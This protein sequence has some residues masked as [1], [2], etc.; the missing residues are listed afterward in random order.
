MRMHDYHGLSAYLSSDVPPMVVV[1]WK[2][3]GFRRER[4]TEVI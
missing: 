4:R 3:V 1:W 2:R